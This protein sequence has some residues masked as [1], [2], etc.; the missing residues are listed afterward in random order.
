MAAA[1][2]IAESLVEGVEVSEKS[3]FGL[4]PG[5][6]CKKEWKEVEE[7]VLTEHL[8]R[9]EGTVHSVGLSAADFPVVVVAPETASHQ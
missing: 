8:L 5:G 6:C 4:Q 3:K 2:S 7:L 9:V 1:V